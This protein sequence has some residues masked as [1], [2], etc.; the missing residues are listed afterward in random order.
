MQRHVAEGCRAP[1]V[2][3]FGQ[4]QQRRDDRQRLV[5]VCYRLVRD[6]L[7]LLQRRGVGAAALW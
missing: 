6:R 2:F 4:P 7:E 3:D 5:N 1:A